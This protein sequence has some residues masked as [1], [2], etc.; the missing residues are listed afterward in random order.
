MIV[1]ESKVESIHLHYT[2]LVLFQKGLNEKDRFSLVSNFVPKKPHLKFQ[3]DYFVPAVQLTFDHSFHHSKIRLFFFCNMEFVWHPNSMFLIMFAKTKER[4]PKVR[5]LWTCRLLLREWEVFASK[6]RYL[7][8][9][10]KSTLFRK[11]YKLFVC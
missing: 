1:L 7:L 2:L 10:S 3:I 4:T 5:L 6:N 9:F 8:K 11:L